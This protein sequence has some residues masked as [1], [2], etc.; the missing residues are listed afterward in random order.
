MTRS[1]LSTLDVAPRFTRFS[2]LDPALYDPA[3]TSPT[4][5]AQTSS[6]TTHA[7]EP[8]AC[9]LRGP[10]AILPPQAVRVRPSW[11][12]PTRDREPAPAKGAPRVSPRAVT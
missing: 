9:V 4:P 3:Q 5:P 2:L 8:T 1:F 11:T 10:L 6:T 12:T 7:L